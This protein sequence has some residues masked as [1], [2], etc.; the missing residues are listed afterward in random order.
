MSKHVTFRNRHLCGAHISDWSRCR[1]FGAPPTTAAIKQRPPAQLPAGP[2]VAVVTRKTPVVAGPPRRASAPP[3]AV[4]PAT[5]PDRCL[6]YA[7][8]VKTRQRIALAK[9]RRAERRP[10]EIRRFSV[11]A[12]EAGGGGGAAPGLP[13]VTRACAGR[14][15]IGRRTLRRPRR[16]TSTKLGGC[17]FTAGRRRSVALFAAPFPP[18]RLYLSSH[19][20]RSGVGL[21]V[22]LQVC[23]RLCECAACAAMRRDA[24]PPA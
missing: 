9:R 23:V 8:H 1:N 3:P 7:S 5:V 4:Q 17:P 20:R 13:H 12:G 10:V 2:D 16:E 6:F 24:A 21:F 22:W 19:P 11:G 15:S 14:L 18:A